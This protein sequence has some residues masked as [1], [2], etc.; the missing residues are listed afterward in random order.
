MDVRKQR[1]QQ[2]VAVRALTHS[3]RRQHN[4]QERQDGAGRPRAPVG[5]GLDALI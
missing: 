1:V 3:N 2:L 4:Q 5:S